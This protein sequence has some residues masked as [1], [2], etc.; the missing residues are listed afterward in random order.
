MKMTRIEEEVL[1]GETQPTY[2]LDYRNE[3]G[4]WKNL[5]SDK[6]INVVERREREYKERLKKRFKKGVE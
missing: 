4:H 6:S 1:W 3:L 5:M 2:F